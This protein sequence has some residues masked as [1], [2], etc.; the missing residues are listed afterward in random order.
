MGYKRLKTTLCNRDVF[1]VFNMNVTHKTHYFKTLLNRQFV[2]KMATVFTK[3]R[4]QWNTPFL[5]GFVY[6]AMHVGND[7]TLHCLQ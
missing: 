3:T 7:V 4:H 1:F 5:D 6:D 2:L